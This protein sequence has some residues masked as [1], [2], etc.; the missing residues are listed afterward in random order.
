MSDNL[1]I[2]RQQ[3][4]HPDYRARLAD[5]IWAGNSLSIEDLKTR[6]IENPSIV[7]YKA[8]MAGANENSPYEGWLDQLV[9]RFSAG[10][11]L[12]NCLS[13][14]AGR[15]RFEQHLIDSGL[16]DTFEEF[17][18]CV[19]DGSDF[20][21]LNFAHLK[22]ESYDL[23]LCHGVLHHLINLEFV[24]DQI[25][26]ALKP[27]GIVLIY[28]YIGERQWQFSSDR[29][30]VLKQRFP[31]VQFNPVPRW[32]I[33]GFEAVRS[34]DLQQLIDAVFGKAVLFSTFFG[35]IYFPFIVCAQGDDALFDQVVEF[36]QEIEQ[37]RR[38]SPCYHLG[39][40]GKTAC[41]APQSNPW[42]DET[43]A[44]RL[45]RGLP[46]MPM[47]VRA[48]HLSPIGPILRRIRRMLKTVRHPQS[49]CTA[50]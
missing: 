2:T 40:Y 49:Q 39:V 42:S 15:G 35:A 34:D 13:I 14:G 20:M 38:L 10:R 41:R 23:I 7:R 1:T 8:K 31:G 37:T 44:Q 12:K 36:D 30:A 3:S 28:E 22:H 45:H 5:E 4:Q 6:K 25:N 24:L 29:M 33:G 18:V 17:D 47:I 27:D 19:Q 50:S 26:G 43:L 9:R 16:C 11:P 32:A 48:L 21:D 46:L